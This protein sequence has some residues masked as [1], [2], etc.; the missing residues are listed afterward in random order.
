MLSRGVVVL[1]AGGGLLSITGSDII[2]PPQCGQTEILV[3]ILA[4]P[5]LRLRAKFLKSNKRHYDTQASMPGVSRSMR[6][7][8]RLLR[9]YAWQKDYVETD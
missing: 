5:N 8:V 2:T 3:K 9:C 1:S 6:L 7:V 4:F